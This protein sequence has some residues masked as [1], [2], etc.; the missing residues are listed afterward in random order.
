MCE[1]A[2]VAIGSKIYL[3]GGADMY[4]SRGEK[5][6]DF[7]SEAAHDGQPVG[8]ALLVLDTADP[9][10]LAASGRLAR[11]PALTPPPPSRAGR[12]TRARWR[13]PRDRR[14]RIDVLQHHR[15]LVLRP[16]H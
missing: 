8:R 1:A 11:L 4:A 3:V 5:D 6:A 7:N 15:R 16:R 13:S 2:A 10:R 14:R 12:F 9:R